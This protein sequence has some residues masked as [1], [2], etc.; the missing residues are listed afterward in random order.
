MN[1]PFTNNAKSARVGRRRRHGRGLATLVALAVT[2][3]AGGIAFAASN[4]AS[5]PSPTITS[6]PAG[7][8][9][10]TSAGF[11][12]AGSPASLTFQCSLDGSDF[13]ACSSP[14]A[15]AGPLAP[16]SHT[17]RV[18]ARTSAGRFSSP[19]SRTWAVD[20]MAPAIG[21]SFPA[22]GS[23]SYGAARW[24]S[25]CPSGP[26]ICGSAADPSGVA[27]VKLS[28]RQQ[29]T[30]K[31]WNGSSFSSASEVFNAATG[32]TS[33][34]YPLALPASDGAY[35]IHAR[36]TDGLGNATA[37]GSQASSSFTID[38]HAPPVPQLVD[39]PPSVSTSRRA[40]FAFT[41]AEPGVSFL[42][43]L[44]GEAFSPC[45]SPERLD[46]L[47]QGPHHFSV[48]ARDAAGNLSAAASSSWTVDTI[49]PPRP[50]ITQNPSDPSSSSAATFA[51]TDRESGV[52][53]QC[54]LD[55]GAW[56][57]SCT[58]PVGYSGLGV[59]KHEFDVRAIDAAGNRSEAAEFEWKVKQQQGG[60]GF[61]VA[62]GA[63]GAL[64]PGVS[65]PLALTVTNPNSV[66]ISVTSLTVTVQPGSTK[67][68]CDGP[69]NLQVTESNASASNPLVVP[70]GGH[71]TL[72]SGT[73]SAPQALMK[74]LPTNQD[75]C[76]GAGFSFSYGGSAHS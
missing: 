20:T 65:Q 35:S 52:G 27:S 22:G 18:R 74:D 28:V 58:S 67:P 10:Q 71:V 50:R 39:T 31:Y 36:A 26:G 5:V 16:G 37:P 47:S 32:T 42:C 11:A 75:A 53:F 55:G 8:T 72:P 21:L 4:E 7:P 51:F 70:A 33:W 56:T 6:G 3:L 24:S 69:T 17:F 60:A 1:L 34:R 68:G 48:E 62:G 2:A 12:F 66:A 40:T 63:L 14:K 41:D 25:G 64:F 9:S 19:A 59:G 15:Y 61:T 45:S 38:T 30:G 43:R 49:A 46:G 29:A 57:A 44:D 54:R 13:T 23:S 76:K 73:V